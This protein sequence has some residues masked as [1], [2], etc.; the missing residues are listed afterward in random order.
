MHGGH[1]DTQTTPESECAASPAARGLSARRRRHSPR[2]D[3]G[4]TPSAAR[5]PWTGQVAEP[6]MLGACFTRRS[7]G[8]RVARENLARQHSQVDFH[9]PASGGARMLGPSARYS[10]A[11]SARSRA[12]CSDNSY[13]RQPVQRTAQQVP[14]SVACLAGCAGQAGSVVGGLSC[15]SHS[16][17]AHP[18]KGA[19]AQQRTAQQVPV[20]VTCPAGCAGLPTGQTGSVV[21]G[22]FCRL[23][24]FVSRMQ[25]APSSRLIADCAGY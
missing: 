14:L 21:G 6:R 20:S 7:A 13:R 9:G 2:S 17:S 19:S 5:R 25:A 4:R 24:G 12:G 22:L 18:R 8:K 10:R 11:G 3:C 23:P 15:R 16:A 1:F